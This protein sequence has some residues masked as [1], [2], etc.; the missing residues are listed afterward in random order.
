MSEWLLDTNLL[1]RS[2]DEQAE[3]H[4]SALA[5]LAELEIRGNGLHVANQ[6]LYEFWVV[7]SRP[8]ERNGL[9]LSLSNINS[10][11]DEFIK[12]YRNLP[13]PCDLLKEWRRLVFRYQI[14]NFQSS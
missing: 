6:S 3:H 8:V 5:A 11:L 2:V 4:A 9:G 10:L 14:K 7:A 13:D 12:D 1:L